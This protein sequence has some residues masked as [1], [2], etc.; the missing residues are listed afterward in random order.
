MKNRADIKVNGLQKSL[1]LLVKTSFVVFIG[2]SLSKIL[3]YFYRALIARYYGPEVYGLFSIALMVSGWFI[4]LSALGLLEGLMRF[5]PL[6]RGK[7][8]LAKISYILKFSTVVLGITSILSGALMF[9]LADFISINLFHNSALIIYIKLFSIAVPITTLASIFL[10]LL[11]AFEE[12]AWYSFIFNILQNI[13]KVLFLGLFVFLGIGSNATSLSYLIGIF[14]IF[15]VAYIVCKYKLPHVFGLHELNADERNLVQRELT[16]YSLPLLFFAVISTIFYWIDSFSIGYFRG[17]T[18]VGFYNA[19]VPIAALLAITPELFMQLF[20]PMITREYSK[21]NLALIEQ[22]SKQVAK[23]ILIVNI[24]IFAVLL[25]FPGAAINILFGSQYLVAQN[26]LRILAIGTLVSAIFIVSNYLMSMIGKSKL[27]LVNIVIASVINLVLNV[28]LVPMQK[29][30][31]LDNTYGLVG[32]S[33]ATLISVLV[34]NLLFV[35]QTHRYL[36]IVPLRRKMITLLLIAIIPTG[37][38]FYL[39]TIFVSND[40][41]T[42]AILFLI[43]LIV[44]AVLI[45]VCGVLDENDRGIITGIYR[46]FSKKNKRDKSL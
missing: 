46:K 23:W 16:R 38:L 31:F 45:L 15:I 42:L 2:I 3:G 5:I 34:F 26:A 43:F 14:G 21:K 9:L 19:A 33:V 29:V 7:K 1:K 32:A 37:L 13:L 28:I 12:I 17:A 24:P 41:F 22:L 8:E 27:I 4:A 44:Y 6:Y 20:F 11:R 10:V 39:R 35:I 36:S 18:E 40:L 25:V 30:W